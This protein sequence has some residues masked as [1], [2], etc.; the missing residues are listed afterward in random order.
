MPTHALGSMRVFEYALRGFTA[1]ARQPNGKMGM[2][3]GFTLWPSV[4]VQYVYGMSHGVGP[5]GSGSTAGDQIET[6]ELH[7][8]AYCSLG[9][10]I[11]LVDV[12]G[13]R[14]GVYS[15]VGE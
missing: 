1:K 7:D 8:A 9:D 11:Q 15:F 5:K 10:A 3:R 2:M 14:C 13:A 12:R 4:A 6:C